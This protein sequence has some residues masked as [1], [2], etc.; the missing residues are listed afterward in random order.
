MVE[1]KEGRI[2]ALKKM[3][4]TVIKWAPVIYPVVRKIMKDRKASKQK[5][6]SAS[7]T[8]G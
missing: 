2:G 6:M 8:A 5:N 7:R 1:K 4:K 3:I